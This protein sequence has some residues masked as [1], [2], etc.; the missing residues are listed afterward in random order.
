MK[1][2]QFVFGIFC[3]FVVVLLLV[4]VFVVVQVVIG[5]IQGIIIDVSGSLL[6]GVI[7]IVKNQDIGIGCMVIMS[8]VGIYNVKVLCF[9]VYE[10]VVLFEGF[11]M[12]C[13][14]DIQIFMCQVKDINLQMQVELIFE[15]I[16]VM[17]EIFFI[18]VLCIFVVNYVD[19]VV[20]DNL[21]INGC[22]FIIFVILILMVQVDCSCGFLIMS[23]QCGIYIDFNV[24]GVNNKLSFFGYGCG[25]EVME[26]DGLIIVQDLV[27]EFKIVVNEFLLEFGCF[28]GGFINVVI[29]FGMN[30]FQGSVFVQYC[31]DLG[32][33]DLLLFLLDDFCGVDGFVLVDEFEC[34]DWGFLFGG[35]I[36]QDK[37][38]F[39]F[40]GDFVGCDEFFLCM[41]NVEINWDG[42]GDFGLLNC[43][44]VYDVILFCVQNEL[45]FVVFVDGFECCVDGMVQGNFVCLV[46]NMIFFGKIDQQWIDIQQMLFCIN[47]IDYECIF[48]FFDEELLKVEEMFFV[49]GFW[50][51]IIGVN[52]VNEFCFQYV[53]DDFDCLLQCVGQLI[54][55]Q[56]CFLLLGGFV[57]VGKFD[58]L[59]IFVEEMQMQF[60]NDFLYF[61]GVY[62]M[63]FGVDYLDDDLKQFFV[64]LCDGCYDFFFVED[65]FNNEVGCVCIYFGNVQF[66]NY[67]EVQEFFGIYVQDIWKMGDLMFNYGICYE[68]EYNLDNFDYV[69]GDGCD[70]LDDMDNIGFCIGF[71][72]S[73]N[74][75]DVFCVG[76]GFF[77]GCIVI[78]LFV[79]QIQENGIFLNFGCIMVCLGQLG[80]VLLGQQILNQ[81]LLLL[82]V[83]LSFFVDLDW[84]LVEIVCVNVGYECMFSINWMVK[85]DVIY[86][87]GD[88]FQCNVDINCQ[89]EC[90]D[91]FG[92][93]IYFDDCLGVVVFGFEDMIINQILV[94]CFIGNLEYKVFIFVVCK[95]YLNGF[96]FDVYYMWFEDEDDDFNECLVIGVMIIDIIN[97]GYDWGLLDCNVENCFVF[98][99]VY[100]FFWEIK[101]V[102]VF[103]YC[104]GMLFLVQEQL[105]DV[106]N[107]LF[108]NGFFGDDVFVVINGQ[109]IQWNQF[110]NEDVIMFDLCFLKFFI[111]GENYQVD[112]YLQ[113]FNFFDE[114][115]F[116]VGGLQIDLM[117][118]SGVVNFEFGILNNLFMQQC[119]I[120]YGVCFSF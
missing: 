90:Y 56:V 89:I 86:V 88:N 91:E 36:K 109:L 73:L 116:I 26:N 95:C 68:V 65:F 27:Q 105:V 61:F 119:Q 9:G 41:I 117:F 21:L 49:I 96:L 106:Y 85:V 8:V 45:N 6:F 14:V 57:V 48:G 59:L 92:C 97:F 53:M 46:D 60:C 77:F 113:V 55:V 74:G 2:F 70:I 79:S 120:E 11:Q 16:M 38:Y 33:V 13:Q 12:I 81:N 104:D 1:C 82:M 34:F 37:M 67:D 84:E 102:G 50:M 18:E 4:F 39:F 107:Y 78:L 100:E 62:D 93:L 112:I 20:I 22:D 118:V 99:V 52:V 71:V 63:K 19:E 80:F 35:L 3:F 115:V 69:F 25:G 47:F 28:G 83:F 101:V 110:M 40:V 103:E 7:V 30:Q 51:L 10:V 54:E 58:F 114:N 32:V 44:S 111:F 66:L 43:F 5:E 98:I 87:E 42:C 24:D 31:D 23:G 72:W 76:V 15:V 64:G 108:G 94:C 75:I 29:K 17:V